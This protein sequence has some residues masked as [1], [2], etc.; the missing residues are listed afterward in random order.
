MERLLKT[1]QTSTT[2]ANRQ[3]S[4]PF[5]SKKHEGG[6]FS[7]TQEA[8]TPFFT[9]SNVQKK[10]KSGNNRVN[11]NVIVQR[12][13]IESLCK[14]NNPSKKRYKKLSDTSLIQ[15]QVSSDSGI[16]LNNGEVIFGPYS[17]E[18]IDRFNQIYDQAIANGTDISVNVWNF[19]SFLKGESVVGNYVADYIQNLE[20]V[21][22]N[23]QNPDM[24][25]RSGVLPTYNAAQEYSNV[26]GNCYST[27]A[28]R[29]NKGYEDISK[30]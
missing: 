28:S 5:F 26:G 1:K 8:K 7:N 9:P 23:Y 29:I 13:E 6:F 20:E 14:E 22:D 4:K 17:Q 3:S 16:T 2:N 27:T 19:S 21:P 15:R 11:S 24:F 10:S 25:A 30:C 12:K 18:T